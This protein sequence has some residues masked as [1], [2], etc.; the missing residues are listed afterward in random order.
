ML[1]F[2]INEYLMRLKRN[3]IIGLKS[4]FETESHSILLKLK[5]FLNNISCR[6][7]LDSERIKFRKIYKSTTHRSENTTAGSQIIRQGEIKLTLLND[8][9]IKISYFVR[10]NHIIFMSLIFGLIAGLVQWYFNNT[11]LIISLMIGL[12]IAFVIFIIG[13]FY[14]WFK[15]NELVRLCL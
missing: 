6:T 2:I 11:E 1:G 7:S 3:I 13:Y 14:I 8:D 4:N 5:M 10:L 15:M 12:I 9:K